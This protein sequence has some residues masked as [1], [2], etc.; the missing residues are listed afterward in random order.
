MLPFLFKYFHKIAY[1][2]Y[3]SIG[4]REEEKNDTFC[5]WKRITIK[6]QY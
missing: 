2:W 3:F 6:K 1:C 4:F 5:K